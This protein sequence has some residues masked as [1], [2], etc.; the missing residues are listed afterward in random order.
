MNNMAKIPLFF[1]TAELINYLFG[2]SSLSPIGSELLAKSSRLI[3]EPLT[4]TLLLIFFILIAN[5]VTYA[6]KKSLKY[7]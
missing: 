1:I 2:Y 6:F 4:I 3:S 5:V 7:T